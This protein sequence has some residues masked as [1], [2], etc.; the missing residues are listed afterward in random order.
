MN[1]ADKIVMRP[2][3]SLVPYSSNARAHT[4]AQINLIARSIEAFGFTNPILVD[5]ENGIV[6]GHARLQAAQK[7]GLTEVPT[8]ELSSQVGYDA[9]VGCRRKIAA[10]YAAGFCHRV[11]TGW[12]LNRRSA[13]AVN[14][15]RRRAWCAKK[16][17]H[18]LRARNDAGAAAGGHRKGQDRG[19][20]ACPTDS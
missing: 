8:I 3:A 15:A 18:E 2:L 4:P 19:K 20:I 1:L 11:H 16:L 12:R 6:A 14:H 7:V 17:R 5:G 9:Q 13:N 10:E